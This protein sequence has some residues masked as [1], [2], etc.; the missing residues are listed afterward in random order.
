[1]I[2]LQCQACDSDY[3]SSSPHSKYCPACRKAR[4]NVTRSQRT[5]R[6]KIV[7][8]SRFVGV[9]GEGVT[10]PDGSHRYVLL[11]V[12]DNTPLTNNGEHLEWRQIFDYL[13]DCFLF[14]PKAIYVGYYLGY[15]FTQWLRTLPENRARMLLDSKAIISRQRRGANLPPFPV[16]CFGWEF[17]TLGTRRFKLRPT[18][19]KAWMTI[20]DAGPFYQSSFLKAIDPAGWD[21][22]IVSPEDYETILE[23]KQHRSTAVLDKD[24]MRYNITENR[25]MADLMKSLDDGFKACN[26]QLNRGQWF[27]PGQAAQAWLTAIKAPTGDEIRANTPADVLRA[28]QETYYGGWFEVFRHG[29]QPGITYEYDINSAYPS[30]IA[31]LPDFRYGEWKQG[32]HG[33]HT[34]IRAATSSSLDY[35]GSMPHRLPDG[36][37]LRPRVTAGWYWAHELDAAIRAGVCS[38]EDIY[39]VWSFIPDSTRRPYLDIKELYH[40]RL[41]VGKNSPAG[42]ALKLMYNSAYGKMAQSVGTPKFS[43][44]LTA[45]LITSGTRTMILDAIATHPGGPASVLMVATDGIYFDSPHPTLPLS[46]TELGSW[47]VTEKTNLSIFMPGVYW[48]DRARER[49][50]KGAGFSFKSRGIN[51]ADL[52]SEISRIDSLWESIPDGRVELSQFPT[53]TL[54]IRFGMVTATEA[55]VRGKWFT[56]GHVYSTEHGTGRER[57]LSANPCSKRYLAEKVNGVIKSTAWPFPYKGDMWS[58]PYANCF[59]AESESSESPEVDALIDGEGLNYTADIAELLYED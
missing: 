39:E 50:R 3:C 51:A 46:S 56:A 7:K 15:D 37:I 9:D 17:D 1:M 27:G 14:D 12:G 35:F 6:R 13:Y 44:A 24:M 34:M 52:A 21:H 10:L 32:R 8:P 43:S 29:P 11:T 22:P 18:G 20:C 57:K 4:H 49:I 2:E 5:D 45:S 31:T 25:V 55:L 54:P 48:D 30:V 47:D 36:R 23:G 42:R 28:A 41:N 26:I 40:T 33:T 59:G 38:I 19:A 16:E 58:T 53:V